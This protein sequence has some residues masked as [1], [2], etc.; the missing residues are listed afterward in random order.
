MDGYETAENLKLKGQRGELN[1]SQS[2]VIALTGHSIEHVRENEKGKYFDYIC[3]IVLIN[4][5]IVMKPVSKE[6]IQEVMNK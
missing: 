1:L 2:K 4:M 5:Y 3:K 6:R